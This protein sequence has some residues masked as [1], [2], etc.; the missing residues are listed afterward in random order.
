LKIKQ[1]NKAKLIL[2]S[3]PAKNKAIIL[4][5]YYI[6]FVLLVF[7]FIP[8]L[9]FAQ[10]EDL[11][12]PPEI[13][14]ASTGTQFFSRTLKTNQKKENVHQ[15]V[16][17]LF[18]T[19]RWLRED[20]KI[21]LSQTLSTA[22]LEDGPSLSGLENT[23][24]RATYRL[25]ENTLTYLGLSLPITSV[26]SDAETTYLSDL[27]FTEVL[28][29]R[30]SRISEGRNLDIG[31][32]SVY[33]LQNLFLGIGAGYI[34]KGSYDRFFQSTETISYNPGNVLSLNIGG[35]FRSRLTR[36]TGKILYNYYGD[37]TIGEINFKTGNEL[38]FLG[39]A[40][41]RL[42][43]LRLTLFLADTIKGDS[44]FKQEEISINNPFRNRLNTG[45]T[46]IYPLLNERLTFKTEVNH[47]RL[48]DDGGEYNA[49][50]TDFSGGFQLFI[51]DNFALD[52]S[53]GF[54]GG[55]M[56][57]GQTDISGYNLGFLGYY[58]F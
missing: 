36:V 51:T 44:T 9:S 54:I 39:T 23:K 14:S 3:A 17:P 20:L 4:R 46:A 12:E 55:K 7:L 34:L 18:A 42:E 8:T 25:F 5:D 16:F 56:D 1:T 22:Q 47:K 11:S 13:L 41:L 30:V 48:F 2:A 43:F 26:A 21:S 50:V 58:G 49:N 35:E 6:R 27:L 31:F 15:W 29:F 45:V 52:I 37:D 57:N 10:V 33:P 28:K 24:I 32:A 38:T 53:A 40:T 19:S